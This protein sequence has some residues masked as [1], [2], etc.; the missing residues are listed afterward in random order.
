VNPEELDAHLDEVLVF[1]REPV[2]PVV[3]EY[4]DG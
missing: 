1:G 4:D 2:T 3:V